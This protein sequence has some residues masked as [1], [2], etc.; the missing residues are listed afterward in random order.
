MGSDRQDDLKPNFLTHCDDLE[1]WVPSIS[2]YPEVTNITLRDDNHL[3]V[4]GQR[5]FDRKLEKTGDINHR[6]IFTNQ[7]KGDPDLNFSIIFDGFWPPHSLL[8]LAM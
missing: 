4:K 7:V 6:N 1:L 5:I 8:S 3:N 2:S